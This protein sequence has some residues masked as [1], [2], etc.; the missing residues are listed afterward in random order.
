MENR[1]FYLIMIGGIIILSV[2]V[3]FL[4]F[5]NKKKQS[6]LVEVISKNYLPPTK[7]P[8]S[9]Q[10]FN[11]NEQNISKLKSQLVQGVQW[12]DIFLEYR[13][14]ADI[15]VIFYFGE[16]KEAERKADQFFSQKNINPQ[17]LKIEYIGLQKDKEEAPFGFYQ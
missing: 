14:S 8:L 6:K 4:Y 5:Q 10:K 15:I 17:N 9:K 1:K 3:I 2:I 16:K 11:Q 13:P 7:I 12:E